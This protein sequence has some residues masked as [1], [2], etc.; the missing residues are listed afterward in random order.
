MQIK[1]LPILPFLLVLSSMSWPAYGQTTLGE[2]I[3]DMTMP[4]EGRPHGVPDQF[5]W[6]M[7]PRPGAEAPP[8][9]WDAAIAWGQLYEWIEGNPAT[10]SRVQIRDLEMYYLSKHDHQW[11]L[12]QSAVRVDGASYVEDFAGD[13]NKPANMR[14]EEDGSVSVTCGEGYNFHFWPK[15]GRINYPKNDVLG[16][17]VSVRARLI[18]DDPEGVDDRPMARYVMSVG[19]DWWESL[20]AVWDNWTTN[21]DMGIG[22]FRFVTGEW[23]SF[24]MISLPGD[25]V[26]KYPPPFHTLGP[27]APQIYLDTT[28]SIGE[29]VEDLLGKMLL[30]EKVGQMTQANWKAVK[31]ASNLAAYNLGSLLNGGG[32]APPNN[33]P[34]GW[35]DMIQDFQ[36][37]AMKTRLKIPMLYGTDA[38][39]GHN[40]LKG[41]VI[42]PH[43]IG[44]GCTRNESLVEAAARITALEAAACGVTWTFAPCI[45]VPR[46][47]R[48]GRTYEG[49]SENPDLVAKMGAAAIRG[50]QGATLSDS[51]RILACAKHYLGDGGTQNGNDQGNT[52]LSEAELRR[53]HLAPY[54]NAI[55]ENVG[56]VMA[57]YNSWNSSK[58]HGNEYLLSTVLKEELG[59]NGFIVSDW[60]AIDQLP[61]DYLS[62]IETSINAGIDMVMVPNQYTAFHKGLTGLVLDGKISWD[63]IDDANRRILSQK[64]KLG[65]FENPWPARSL[66]DLVG[67]DAHRELAQR[68]VRESLVLLKN[69]NRI[70]PLAKNTGHIHVAGNSA[71]NLGN[72]CGGWT[73]SWQGGSG[74]ITTGTTILEAIESVA[75]GQVS[76]TQTG[77][78]EDAEGATVA[79]VVI[80][81][82]PYAEGAG[83]REDLQPD[84]DQVQIIKSLYDKG[85][86]VITIL[87]SGRPLLLEQ[88]WHYSD[89]VIAAWLPGTEGGGVTDILFGD[90]MPTGKLSCTWPASIDQIPINVGDDA[91]E[92]FLP[93]GFGIDT[94]ALPPV[95][96][97]PGVLS[98]AIAPDESRIE[99][100]FDKP[101]KLATASMF[102]LT[103]NN[104]P[105]VVEMVEIKE[106]DSNTFLITCDREFSSTDLLFISS[107]G[108]ITAEDG[109]IS[110]SFSIRVL[111]NLI[112]Y[113]AVP[114]RIEA[115]DY[116]SMSG[117]RTETC[118]DDGGGLNVGYIE[119][120]DNMVY[121][122]EIANA[123]VHTFKYRVASESAGKSLSL[124]I[125]EGS[126]WSTLHTVSFGPTGGYQEWTTTGDTATLPAGKQT[127]RILAKSS[128]FNI[129]WVEIT[130]GSTDSSPLFSAGASFHI[131]PNPAHDILHMQC[132]LQAPAHYMIFT[133]S[134]REVA[135]GSFTSSTT[136]DISGLPPAIYLV[137]LKIDD[138]T[139]FRKIVVN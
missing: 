131:W 4:H 103:V 69:K 95:T 105:A 136:A 49:F 54:V 94:F 17:Y 83:D 19:G 70:L 112:D 29:R 99:L 2:I 100:T 12:L 137:R 56:S 62:D 3:N 61:G 33:S 117:I 108:G 65:L 55:R 38:V 50:F 75:T 58:L 35:A 73:I 79:I 119:P 7:G 113:H 63:R 68:C 111:N 134:G 124:Q 110:G 129:N 51:S 84:P 122:A 46:D 116:Y 93:Y 107:N 21:W 86:K 20:T 14:L 43:N 72:Q 87:I 88:L 78:S 96:L 82:S 64:F 90:H 41:A 135:N 98:A 36:E 127:L 66:A 9:T 45:A 60:S 11:H 39:H 10:N 48:W 80:G 92:P 139:L 123:G 130:G 1:H 114:G 18:L 77:Y 40:N 138:Q 125:E 32:D 101:M 89:A 13:V 16:S 121:K 120:G 26:L 25:S 8:E 34:Q 53:I 57:S 76:F 23:K 30:S 115:E 59:F 126:K 37:E 22:R 106:G 71:D 67:N 15:E 27:D 133:A 6:S 74:D 42:F 132:S 109:S 5:D 128:Q 85:I 97:A 31:P 28:S 91:Y 44:M 81:E 24:N 104:L 102:D 52:L 118:N 47:E